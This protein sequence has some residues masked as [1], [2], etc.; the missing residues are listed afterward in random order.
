MLLLLMLLLTLTKLAKLLL[1]VLR[2]QLQEDEDGDAMAECSDVAAAIAPLV[3]ITVVE[4]KSLFQLLKDEDV[5][6]VVASF[7]GAIGADEITEAAGRADDSVDVL[8]IG[9]WVVDVEV[10]GEVGSDGTT[11]VRALKRE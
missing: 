9:I 7:R 5:V 6:K 4:F 1:F 11:D 8:C 3:P 10:I 2:I